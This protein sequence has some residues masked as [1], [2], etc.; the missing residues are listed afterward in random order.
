MAKSPTREHDDVT[1]LLTTILDDTREDAEHEERTYQRALESKREAEQAQQREAEAHKR[2]EAERRMRAEAERQRQM[3]TAR[4][5]MVRAIEGPSDRELEAQ[6]RAQEEAERAAEFERR[7]NA[8]EAARHEAEERAAE[9]IREARVREEQRLQALAEL[10]PQKA[11]KRSAAA[12]WMSAAAGAL[13]LAVT[14]TAGAVGASAWA[15]T[16]PP[17]QVYA[18]ITL[19]PAPLQSPAMVGGFVPLPEV[20]QEEV[21]EEVVTTS[22][23]PNRRPRH[24]A[25]QPT[26]PSRANPFGDLSVGDDVFGSGKE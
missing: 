25:T 4:L 7:L 24:K 11:P 2:A 12:V 10:T 19:S 22:K 21:T 3:H 23:R 8:V 6:R 1:M 14:M 26:P 5:D 17:E 20:A 18:K 15:D 13:A 16:T 9:A